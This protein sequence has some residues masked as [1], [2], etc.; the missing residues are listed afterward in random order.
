[1]SPAL[2]HGDRLLL[3]PPLV[4]GRGQV[5]VAPDPRDPR[6]VLC[7][8]VEAVRGSDVWL[9][10]DNLARSTDSRIFGPVPRATLKGV[11]IWRYAPKGREGR[12]W[13][14]PS[15]ATN[16]LLCPPGTFS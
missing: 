5:V 6:R 15:G 8:R 1:M 2:L 4:L 9:V 16:R 7:K 13:R 3:A 14:T 11:A 12:S 10:G